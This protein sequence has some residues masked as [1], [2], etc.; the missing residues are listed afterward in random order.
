VRLFVLHPN[1]GGTFM[2]E[3]QSPQDL[4]PVY[5]LD[6]SRE[7]F[8]DPYSYTDFDTTRPD[9]RRMVGCVE[10]RNEARGSK[11]I[12]SVIQTAGGGVGEALDRANTVYGHAG[13]FI[14][15][16]DALDE[17]TKLRGETV[18]GGHFRCK[19]VIGMPLILAEMINLSDYAKEDFEKTARM[20]QIAEDLKPVM[21]K[22]IDAAKVQ[23][24]HI[25]EKGATES[26]VEAV[27]QHYPEHSNVCEVIDENQSEIYITNHTRHAALNRDKKAK[28]REI[29]NDI[30]GYHESR[31]AGFGDI[32]TSDLD[33]EQR[34]Y[35]IG[36]FM[37]RSTASR[38][39]LISLR[40]NT[41][42]YEVTRGEKGL[43]IARQEGLD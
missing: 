16:E 27:H 20:Y 43:V 31:R 41:E 40:P 24:E 30:Q 3:T 18:L 22:I 42:A 28:Q 7:Y 23:L 37:L 21:P 33:R 36:A 25:E 6:A 5:S 9:F 2:A 17:E 15:I 14:G 10:P 32:F 11:K 26:L 4:Q 39:V 38:K 35:R 13:R 29:G 34:T 1:Y 19:F 8:L 12:K